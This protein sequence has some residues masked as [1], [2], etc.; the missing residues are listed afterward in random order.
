MSIAIMGWKELN[1]TFFTTRPKTNHGARYLSLGVAS[2]AKNRKMNA[3]V[4]QVYL[5]NLHETIANLWRIKPQ[6][7]AYYQH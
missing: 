2:D 4:F 6:V 7:V 5:R 3:V 1:Y